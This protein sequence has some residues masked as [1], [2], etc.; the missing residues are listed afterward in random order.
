M[1]IHNMYIHKGERIL[2]LSNTK[3][4][5]KKKNL[6][7]RP[8]IRKPIFRFEKVVGSNYLIGED[9]QSQKKR[10]EEQANDQR[11]SVSEEKRK[12]LTALNY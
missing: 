10:T 8:R 11:H 1:I 2:D 9:V 3:K 6:R 4:K 7:K 12:H 5:I